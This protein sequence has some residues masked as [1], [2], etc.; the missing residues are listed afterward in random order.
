MIDKEQAG[1]RKAIFM[2]DAS[3]GF[4]KDGNKN[5]LRAQDIHRIVDVFNRQLEVPRY[6]R[7]VPV[8]EI[9]SPLNDYNLN[10]PRYID[11]SESEDLHDLDGHLNGGIPNRDIDAFDAYWTVFPKLRTT[12]FEDEGVR[13]NGQGYSAARVETQQIRATILGSSEFVAFNARVAA[14]IDSWCDA[15]EAR[16]KRLKV[17]DLPRGVIDKLSE[18]LLAR[19]GNL[20][21]LDPYDVYQCLMD[22]WAE[23]MQDDVYLIAAD[24]WI[25]AAKPRGIVEDKERNIKETPDLTIGRK[26]YKMDLVPPA[27][28]VARYFANEQAAIDGLQTALDTATRELEEFVEE[29]SGDEGLLA[30]AVNDKGK[31]TK[32]AIK[33]RINGMTA[34]I[35]ATVEPDDLADERLALER[36]LELTDAESESAKAVRDAQVALDEQVLAT[37]MTLDLTDIKVL[38]VEDK[39]FASLR[40][41]VDRQVQRL[42]HRLAERLRELDERYA[43]PLPY[44]ERE[45]STLA[46]NVKAHLKK[47]GLA[48]EE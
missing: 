19:C 9:A 37:Y 13:K 32:A 16:L 14:V 48:W 4:L 42:A 7:L 27:L 17:N 28:I 20:P 22:Y 40:A 5:R 45:V 36:C 10:L 39:W 30:D 46:A 25:E 26:K 38:A 12:L 3:R 34:T 24:G 31:V 18:D 33:E 43:Q 29:H 11:S 15:H 41:A 47:M 35:R 44:L 2:I 8:A 23:T 6:S 21:L 1:S